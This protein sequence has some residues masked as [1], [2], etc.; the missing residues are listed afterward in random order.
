MLEA[1]EQ[2]VK[3]GVWFS[4]IDKVY[5]PETLRR[6]WLRVKANK[7]GAGTD[8][9]SIEGFERDLERNLHKLH[10]ELR[11]GSYQPR[12]ILRTYIE[13][14]GSRDKRPLGIPCVRDRVVQSALRFV[15]EPIFER[16]FHPRSY[17]FRPE[18]GCKDALRE[19]DRLLKAGY[20]WVVDA[21]FEDYFGSIPHEPM[22]REVEQHIG[23]GRVLGL[24][25]AFL[26]QGI[27]EGLAQWTPE[28]GTPQGAVI[29]PVLANLYLNSVD[30]AMEAAGYR[31]VR[32]ADDLVIL[33]RSREEAE[34]A[35]KQV[36]GQTTGKGLRIHS[37]KTRLVDARIPG[38]GFDFL[39]Y[40]FE[41]GTRWPRKKSLKKLKEAIR[42]KTGRSN[43][44][45]LECIVG[46]VNGT[47]RGWFEYFKHS[48]KRAFPRLDQWIR[49][50][51][52]SILR[53]RH[54][55][56]GISRGYDH[57]RW[58]N[59]YFRAAGLFSLEDAQRALLQSS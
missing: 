25:K 16:I 49:R 57:Y 4:L 9:Q 2:G 38:Q 45:S 13:K 39:G 15:V 27:M 37:E 58:P 21:D 10:E 8:H 7:G 59:R 54:K 17:G 43:G 26:K 29:S 36:Q 44:K 22:L 34:G 53:R 24:L 3:G 28:K 23:D 5:R 56:K 35:L 20:V 12:P 50:R 40:H 6:A 30:G 51:L 41:A 1:L 48:N 33:C 47:L 52:R 46:D 32:Y 18:R 31:M 14:P 11:T 42:K 19:V 55:R